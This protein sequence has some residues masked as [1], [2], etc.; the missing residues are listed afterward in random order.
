MDD[1][2]PWRFGRRFSFVARTI[3][4]EEE[5]DDPLLIIEPSALRKGFVYILDGAY[6]GR[7]KQSFFQSDGMRDVWWGKASAAYYP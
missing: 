2:E 7:L 1:I 4:Q 5:S 3:L 6:R